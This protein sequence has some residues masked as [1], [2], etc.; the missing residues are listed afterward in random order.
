VVESTELGDQ[1]NA[2]LAAL[3]NLELAAESYR[4]EALLRVSRATTEADYMA[5]RAQFRTSI[6]ATEAAREKLLLLGV[7]GVEID[8]LAEELPLLTPLPSEGALPDEEIPIEIK[9]PDDTQR[10]EDAVQA[11]REVARRRT[12]H[13]E[14]PPEE[15]GRH[16]ARY[17]IRAPI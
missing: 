2:Y 7:R 12:H 3:A 5:A 1:K 13:P 14:M 11:L 4:R 17:T 6:V 9:P 15:N 8:A 16:R 10:R